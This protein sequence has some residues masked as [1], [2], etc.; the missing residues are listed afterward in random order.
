MTKEIIH[1][2]TTKSISVNFLTGIKDNHSSGSLLVHNTV[3]TFP[4]A[5]WI[6]GLNFIFEMALP[7]NVDHCFWVASTLRLI[8]HFGQMF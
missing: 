2:T 4:A 7:T 6:P 5:D 1:F 3:A 8:I